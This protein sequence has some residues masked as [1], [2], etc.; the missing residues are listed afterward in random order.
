MSQQHDA[1]SLFY[2]SGEYTI[3]LA[4]HDTA[5]RLGKQCVR[6]EPAAVQDHR[7]W[8]L[9]VAP[10]GRILLAHFKAPFHDDYEFRPMGEG[11]TVRFRQVDHP[12]VEEPF[13]GLRLF[14]HRDTGTLVGADLLTICR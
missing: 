12:V 13:P 3:L 10:D 6:V 9:E 4:S 14:R 1:T 5:E 8:A 11:V 7:D 2:D